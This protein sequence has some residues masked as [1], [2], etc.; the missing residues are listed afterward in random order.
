VERKC[1]S[2]YDFCSVQFYIYIFNRCVRHVRLLS[3]SLF[4]NQYFD[5]VRSRRRWWQGLITLV[6]SAGLIDLHSY[7]RYDNLWVLRDER[8]HLVDYFYSSFG[9]F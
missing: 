1:A 6:I 5:R 8:V 7:C 4:D 2:N 9:I 3:F